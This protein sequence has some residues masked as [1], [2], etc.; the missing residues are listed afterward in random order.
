MPESCAADITATPGALFW[1][2][3][4]NPHQTLKVLLLHPT[5]RLSSDIFPW[6]DSGRY[7]VQDLPQFDDIKVALA[8]AGILARMYNMR[9]TSHPS[10]FVK[11]AAPRSEFCPQVFK[12]IV[13]LLLLQL[14]ADYMYTQWDE[15]NRQ[16]MHSS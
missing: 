10:E 16:Q 13:W 8:E 4:A 2:S 5:C 11:M 3:S 9:L 14:Q 6:G 1:P 15:G 7:K 12:Q